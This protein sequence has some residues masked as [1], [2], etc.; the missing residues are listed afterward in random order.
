LP[1][2][3]LRPALD[4]QC[5][6]AGLDDFF[7]L[8]D[9]LQLESDYAPFWFSR[10][11]LELH[12]SLLVDGVADVDR[13]DKLPFQRQKGDQIAVHQALAHAQAGDRQWVF[14]LPKAVRVYFRFDRELFRGMSRIVIDELTR[15]MREVKPGFV[16]LDQTFGTLP[17]SYHPHQ[18]ICATDGG[19]LPDGSFVPLPRVRRKDAEALC[20]VHQTV[21]F[22]HWYCFAAAPQ[23]VRLAGARGQAVRGT[24]TEHAFLPPTR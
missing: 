18:H 9:Y 15:Y 2:R 16:V 10:F 7:V 4:E 6:G 3:L 22:A 14:S 19:Y 17:D 20:E 11:A 8:V 24:S 23:G 21:R 13:S 12:G 1:L 5:A